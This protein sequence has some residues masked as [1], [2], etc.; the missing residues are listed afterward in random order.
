M[1]TDAV[2]HEMR[3]QMFRELSA[4]QL[5]RAQRDQQLAQRQLEEAENYICAIVDLIRKCGYAIEFHESQAPAISHRNPR[6][7]R[8]RFHTPPHSLTVFPGLHMLSVGG[9]DAISLV[10]D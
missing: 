3:S 8:S 1:L 2:E 4:L 6:T 5:E 7:G 10:L 9:S